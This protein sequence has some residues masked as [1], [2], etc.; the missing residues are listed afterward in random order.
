MVIYLRN[1]TLQPPSP[2]IATTYFRKDW[3]F[4]K[5]VKPLKMDEIEISRPVK[6]SS[7]I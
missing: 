6:K 3:Q 4:G 7:Q 5:I 1:R 2:K